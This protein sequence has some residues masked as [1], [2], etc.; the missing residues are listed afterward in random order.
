[1]TT[2]CYPDSVGSELKTLNAAYKN[3]KQQGDQYIGISGES[4]ERGIMAPVMLGASQTATWSD[5]LVF[6]LS[7]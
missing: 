2:T 7:D 5:K 3:L 6:G 1:M 4:Y